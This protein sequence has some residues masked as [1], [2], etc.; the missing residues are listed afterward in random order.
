ML[1]DQLVT[2][3]K[4]VTLP[5]LSLT[6]NPSPPLPYPALSLSHLPPYIY[7]HASATALNRFGLLTESSGSLRIRCH[8]VKTDARLARV[9]DVQPIEVI[10]I[11]ANASYCFSH[12]TY[13]LTYGISSH[14]T[15]SHTS[16]PLT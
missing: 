16:P 13:P 8:V 12:M 9:K 14:I 10:K 3:I 15:S 2:L 4:L 7:H 1:S 6:L 5:S 11:N